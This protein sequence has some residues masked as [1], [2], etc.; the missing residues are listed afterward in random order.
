MTSACERSWIALL[1]GGIFLALGLAPQ[2]AAQDATTDSDGY[3]IEAH[4]QVVPQKLDALVE[5]HRGGPPGGTSASTESK[6]LRRATFDLVGRPPS[7]TE[8]EQFAA[9]DSPDKQSRL[10][11]RLLASPEFGTNWANYWSD[12]IAYRVPPPELTYLNYDP[13]KTWLATHLNA[14]TPWH[15]VV[16]ELITG[17][18]KIEKE[19]TATFVGYHQA[20]ATN[21]AAETARIFMG[22]QIGCAECHD[23]PFANWKRV[24]FHGMAA[25]FARSKAKLPWNDGAATV[26]SVL[27]EGE[28]VMSDADDPSAEGEKIAPSFLDGRKLDLGATDPQRRA[29][30]A[31]YVASPDNIWFVRAYTNRVWARLMGR[32]FYEPL[33]DLADTRRPLWPDVHAALTGHFVASGCDVKDLFRV[34]ASTR[35]YAEGLRLRDTV[36]ESDT[37]PDESP[38]RLRGDEVFAALHLGLELPNRTPPAVKPTDAVRFPPPPKSTRELVNQAFGTD[39]SLR[40]VDGP[41]TIAQALWMMN[42]DQLHGEIDATP[43]SGTML[44]RLLDSEPDDARA[45]EQLFMRV[46]ARAATEREVEIAREQVAKLGDR[47][48]AFE[49]LLWA[50]VNSAEFTARR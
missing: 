17:T 15:Q 8:Q 24:Q 35:S 29:A 18:G 1:A 28:Y 5:Q 9:D 7:V 27:D 2:L 33:D 47:R 26:V 44:A 11:E 48:A 10:I 39:P 6:L 37:S 12:V 32:G 49:D 13:L 20:K 45:C 4:G 21:L 34:I 14:N 42:N 46:L 25:F 3:A 38:A 22:Q 19:P 23:H 43:G 36:A 40:P 50:L 30:L 31:E 16:R 41:R